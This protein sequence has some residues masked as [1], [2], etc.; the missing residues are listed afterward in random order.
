MPTQATHCI[1]SGESDAEAPAGMHTN[2]QAGSHDCKLVVEPTGQGSTAS[3]EAKADR[4]LPVTIITRKETNT[5]SN[6]TIDNLT[7][8]EDGVQEQNS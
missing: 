1:A 3:S 7:P 5:M 2:E 4:A 6:E 8:G